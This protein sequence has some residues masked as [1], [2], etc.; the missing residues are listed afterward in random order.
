M[1]SFALGIGTQNTQGNWL[2]IYYP[3]PLHTPN[4]SLVAAAKKALDAPAGN[5]AVSF[6][7]E[8]CAR[9]GEALKAAQPDAEAGTTYE[10]ET[11]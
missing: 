7:P 3:A 1:L 2:D 11:A 8:D 5:A 9:L 6:L 10:G 4:D